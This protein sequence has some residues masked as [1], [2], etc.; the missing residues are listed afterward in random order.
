MVLVINV[1]LTRHLSRPESAAEGGRDLA[2]LPS[3]TEAKP[4]LPPRLNTQRLQPVRHKTKNAILSILASGEVVVEFLKHRIQ[5]EERVV[6]VCR[7]SADGIRVS[8]NKIFVP[9]C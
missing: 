9:R 7:I 8:V 3:A 6:E 4:T 2:R 5:G 1:K